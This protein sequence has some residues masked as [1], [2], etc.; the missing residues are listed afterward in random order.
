M[1]TVQQNAAVASGRPDDKALIWIQQ[2]ADPNVPD[3]ALHKIPKKF[4]NLSRKCSAEFQSIATGELGRRIT[5]I[6]ED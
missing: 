1:N 6:V 5:Q 4:R 2:A 3:E